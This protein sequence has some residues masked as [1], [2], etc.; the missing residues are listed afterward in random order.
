M[1]K[2]AEII[3]KLREEVRYL[4]QELANL[5]SLFWGKKSERYIPVNPA[6]ETLSFG[7]DI[8]TVKQPE[9]NT[10]PE[11]KVKKKPEPGSNIPVRKPIPAHIPRVD[12]VIEPDGIDL[13]KAVKIRDEITEYLDYKPGK[14]FVTRIIRPIYKV[15][16]DQGEVQLVNAELPSQPV[17]K[18]N[19]SAAMMALILVSKYIDHLPIYRQLKQFLREGVDLS[20]STVNGWIHKHLKLLIPLYELAK[21]NV[22]RSNYLMADE[23]PMP[24]LSEDKPGSTHK[25]YYWVYLSP[26]NK[27]ICFEYDKTRAMSPPDLFLKDFTGYL[28]TD[29]YGAYDHFSKADGITLVGCMAHARRK[30]KD[31]NDQKQK[32][33]DEAMDMFG[34]LYAIE[35]QARDQQMDY[36]HRLELRI[37]KSIPVM[38]KLHTWMLIQLQDPE[39]AP[40][41]LLGKAIKYALKIWTRLNVFTKNGML[42][43][44]NNWVEN[45]IRPIALGRRNYMFCGSHEAAQRAAMIY[46]LFAMCSIAEVNPQDWLTDV[47]NRINDHPIN[48]LQDLLPNNWKEIK[49]KSAE[50]ISVA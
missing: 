37:E 30:F 12:T 49:N 10:K 4:K 19:V 15:T 48:K 39:L 27:S 44:D 42:E 24:V 36:A 2:D 29:A 33:A 1:Q 16:T 3:A 14:I 43:I 34:E 38:T 6:Q 20:E 41:S 7:E 8:V 17:A 25:G 21:Q 11:P 26:V 18:S 47:F 28:Q 32:G 5:K 35:R 23:T 46:S 40:K 50:I 45:K 9:V 13:S 22:Q 31:A